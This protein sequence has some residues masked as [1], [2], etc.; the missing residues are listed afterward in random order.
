MP[1]TKT[2]WWRQHASGE[3]HHTKVTNQ[4]HKLWLGA[5]QKP[6][7]RMSRANTWLSWTKSVL[8]PFN[9]NDL[10][11]GTVISAKKVESFRWKRK[12][13]NEQP[14][15][16]DVWLNRTSSDWHHL[17][18]VVLRR[19]DVKQVEWSASQTWMNQ[20]TSDLL[21]SSSCSRNAG[22][23]WNHRR[24]TNCQTIPQNENFAVNSSDAKGQQQ[25]CRKNN[26]ANWSYLITR[27]YNTAPRRCSSN[28][29]SELCVNTELTEMLPGFLVLE[30][31]RALKNNMFAVNGGPN[32]FLV[33]TST[34]HFIWYEYDMIQ[35]DII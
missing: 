14:R 24:L 35:M 16:S 29:G 11:N 9:T 19:M 2:A 33:W 7:S 8:T 31:A 32:N 25:V 12:K 30:T 20:P 23:T 3:K 4:N 26:S 5:W 27:T 10:K 18:A 22:K 28:M 21:S 17:P 15:S 1:P 34:V 6:C 13:N